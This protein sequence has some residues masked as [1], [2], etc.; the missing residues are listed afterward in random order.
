MLHAGCELADQEAADAAPR[1]ISASPPRA[2]PPAARDP[3]APKKEVEVSML[4]CRKLVVSL[5][6]EST[7]AQLKEAISA[8]EGMSVSQMRLIRARRQLLD[9]E[10]VFDEDGA[11]DSKLF[12][13]L[14]MGMMHITSGRDESGERV[15]A[16]PLLPSLKQGPEGGS[17]RPSDEQQPRQQQ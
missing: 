3:R 13:V 14:R 12:L 2:K 16:A 7:V 17:G 11:A 5:P 1:D 4:T 9:E 6:A 8:A 10:P 15:A